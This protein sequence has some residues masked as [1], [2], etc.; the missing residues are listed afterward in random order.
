[1]QV[2]LVERATFPR[3]APPPGE[4]LDS[5]LEAYAA[6]CHNTTWGDLLD[7][8]GLRNHRFTSVRSRHPVDTPIVDFTS[9]STATGI[10]VEVL[11]TLEVDGLRLQPHGGKAATRDVILPVSRY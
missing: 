5:W 10:D 9:L 7:A 6:R 2:A 8:V 3:V 1:M 4:A 11:R